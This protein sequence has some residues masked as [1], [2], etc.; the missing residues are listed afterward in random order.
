D[1]VKS[2]RGERGERS[3]HDDG[4]EGIADESRV[5]GQVGGDDNDVGIQPGRE[6]VARGLPAGL[7]QLSQPPEAE[8]PQERGT[9]RVGTEIVPEGVAPLRAVDGGPEL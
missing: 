5:A 8:M 1:L 7:P 4:V 9:E 6:D 2:P 3:A